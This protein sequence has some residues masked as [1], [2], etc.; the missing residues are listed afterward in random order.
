MAENL[1]TRTNQDQMKKDLIDLSVTGFAFGLCLTLGGISTG[2]DSIKGF[3]TG[4]AGASCLV[5]IVRYGREIS[6][7]INRYLPDWFKMQ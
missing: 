5:A 7:A 2:D 6:S 4:M 1:E 3:G